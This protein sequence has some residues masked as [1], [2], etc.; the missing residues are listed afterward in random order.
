MPYQPEFNIFD[1][2]PPPPWIGPPLPKFLGISWP[3]L[4]GTESFLP[5]LPSLPFMSS[6]E[7]S[8]ENEEIWEWK[9]Y[10]GRDRK[11][12]VTRHARRS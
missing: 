10:R 4:Q 1:L 3:W 12:T 2:L 6:P 5:E 11:I 9:D 8:Y 7:T